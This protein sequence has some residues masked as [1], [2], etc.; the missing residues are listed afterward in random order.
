MGATVAGYF[1]YGVSVYPGYEF[2]KR[3]AFELAGPQVRVRDR[4][5]LRVRARVRARV[6]ASPLS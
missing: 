6:S 1:L 5:R 3:L 4:V 2:F